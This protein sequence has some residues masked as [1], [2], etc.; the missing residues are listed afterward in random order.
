MK[1]MT[2]LVVDDSRIMHRKI[3][4]IINNLG[5]HVKG[6]ATTGEEAITKYEAIKLDLV[7]MDITMPDMDGIEA[8]RKILAYD[9]EAI[10]LMVTSHGQELMVLD[11]IQAGAKGY[12]LK[13]IEEGVTDKAIIDHLTNIEKW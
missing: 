10:I 6:Y 7:T 4:R 13:P 1:A 2:V 9:P 5:G 3:E 11:A 12:V 8:T